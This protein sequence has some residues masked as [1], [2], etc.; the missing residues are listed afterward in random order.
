MSQEQCAL[1][2][3][4]FDLS[5]LDEFA[6]TASDVAT[7]DTELSLEPV[8]EIRLSKRRKRT[9][10]ATREGHITVIHAP[11]RMSKADLDIYVQEL[12][13]KLDARE[14]LATSNARLRD[15]AAVIS[16]KYLDMDLLTTHPVGVSIS[17]VA[18]QNSRWGS[19]S[20]HS[21]RIRISDRLQRAPEF[22]LDAVILHELIHLLIPSHGTEFYD[23][24][25]RYEH[26]ERAHA[27]LD[28]FSA[29]QSFGPRG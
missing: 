26:N 25:N 11:H 17:W 12:V 24:M 10:S 15:R 1:E 16:K 19:C 6:I 21:G 20:P 8:I 23:L 14:N 13:T 18:N 28:G 29:G 27:Y 22:V 4:E 5:E 9:V 3:L 2:F 7:P